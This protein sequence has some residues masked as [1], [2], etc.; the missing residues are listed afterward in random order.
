M[1]V[2]FFV[3]VSVFRVCGL[4]VVLCSVMWVLKW[5]MGWLKFSGSC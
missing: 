2:K 4:V 1:F 3:L 5:L